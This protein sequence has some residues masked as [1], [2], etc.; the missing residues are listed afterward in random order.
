M[1]STVPVPPLSVIIRHE[2]AILPAMAM[3]AGMQLDVF[4]P[5]KDGPLTSTE[6]AGAIG[7]HS[8]KLAPLLYALVAADLLTVQDD[9]FSNTPEADAYFVRGRPTYMAESRQLFYADIWQA[10]LRTADSIRTGAPQHKHD[11]YGM[12]EEEMV[13]F[14]RGQHFYTVASGEQLARIYDLSSYRHMLDVGTGSGGVSIGV[15]RRVADLEITAVDLPKV[16]PVTRRKCRCTDHSLIQSTS[17][18]T[19]ASVA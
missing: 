17:P 2:R 6:V 10:L 9:R 3:L 5:L 4:T 16:I 13:T 18:S 7:V 19:A 1:S 8:A 14:F 15:A 11:F 12:S